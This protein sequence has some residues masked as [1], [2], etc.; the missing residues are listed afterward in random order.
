MWLYYPNPKRIGADHGL[1]KI[2]HLVYWWICWGEYAVRFKLGTL[3]MG[4]WFLH[5]KGSQP[6][7]IVFFH[8]I[9]SPF[10]TAFGHPILV[11][12][13]HAPYQHG[14]VHFAFSPWR[15]MVSHLCHKP[16]SYSIRHNWEVLASFSD[17]HPSPSSYFW[18][19]GYGG[20]LKWGILKIIGF[21][22]KIVQFGMIW[23]YPHFRNLPYM[24]MQLYTHQFPTRRLIAY[25]NYPHG[26][27]WYFY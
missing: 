16:C 7:R 1:F 20:F 9:S 24:V 26:R 25:Q 2:A 27:W 11:M 22:T 6:A 12:C 10:P 4:H 3:R 5:N 21:N 8:L 18:W 17:T 14:I 19:Y 15:K 23:G 13:H